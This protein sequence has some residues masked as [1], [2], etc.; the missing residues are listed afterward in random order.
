MGAQAVVADSFAR[1][2]FHN[3]VNLGLVPVIC[4]G[5]SKKVKEGQTLTVDL[6]AGEIRV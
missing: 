4:K 1:I 3:A 2:F 5:I 6:A